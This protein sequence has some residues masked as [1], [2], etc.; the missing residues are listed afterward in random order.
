MHRTLPLLVVASSAARAAEEAKSGSHLSIPEFSPDWYV[1]IGG[2]AV[3]LWAL[4]LGLL[5]LA[6]AI[7]AV[8]ARR[9]RRS[10]T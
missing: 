1:G 7:A 3:P 8:G 9:H 2:V 10:A 6:T 4:T 5:L